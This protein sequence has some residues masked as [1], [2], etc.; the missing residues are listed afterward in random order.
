M[1]PYLKMRLAEA[2][3]P[4]G[5]KKYSQWKLPPADF[6]YGKRDIKDKEGA[7]KGKI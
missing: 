4:V 5:V 2:E 6:A 7:S 3:H 1:I